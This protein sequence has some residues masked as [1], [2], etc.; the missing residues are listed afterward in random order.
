MEVQ[1]NSTKRQPLL[2]PSD[3]M[4]FCHGY[5]FQRRAVAIPEK[6]WNVP[7]FLDM[8]KFESFICEFAWARA[9]DTAHD[10][11]SHKDLKAL[12]NFTNNH[13]DYLQQV[14]ACLCRF[15]LQS[16]SGHCLL[17]YQQHWVLSC[18]LTNA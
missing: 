5:R 13:A 7:K 12:K 16:A 17:T 8:H 4:C 15:F 14:S 11:R 9:A 10:E 1:G 6:K 3:S 18:R 2:Q